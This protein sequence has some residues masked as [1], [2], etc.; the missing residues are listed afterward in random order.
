[1]FPRQGRVQEIR[2]PRSDG[3]D[4]RRAPGAEVAASVQ[5]GNAEPSWVPATALT[6]TC[7]AGRGRGAGSSRHPGANGSGSWP[8]AGLAP[9]PGTPDAGPGFG[10]WVFLSFSFR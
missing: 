9:T 10:G 4:P 6:G 2:G 7:C 1:M 5:P 8:G 3:L